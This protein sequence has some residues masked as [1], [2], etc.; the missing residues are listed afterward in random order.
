MNQNQT[1]EFV[2]YMIYYPIVVAIFIL[3]CFADSYP[4][5]ITRLVEEVSMDI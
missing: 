4:R 2:S 3:N 1:V 5:N